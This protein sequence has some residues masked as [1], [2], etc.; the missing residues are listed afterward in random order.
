M[1]QT[2]EELIAATDGRQPV[3]PPAPRALPREF[4]IDAQ[5]SPDVVVHDST[6]TERRYRTRRPG[7]EDLHAGA[8]IFERLRRA[9]SLPTAEDLAEMVAV[10]MPREDAEEFLRTESLDT[11]LRTSTEVLRAYTLT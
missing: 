7:I 11:V 2:A 10:Y 9:R 5:A 4:R 1:Q 6:G 8:A 3:P